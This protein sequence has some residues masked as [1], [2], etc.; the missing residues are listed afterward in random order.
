MDSETINGIEREFRYAIQALALPSDQQIRVLSPGDINTEL[1]EDFK[2][3]YPLFLQTARTPLSQ[4][5]KEILAE[6]AQKL[7]SLPDEVFDDDMLDHQKWEEIRR[8][9]KEALRSLFWSETAP[10]E[11]KEIQPGVW[12]RNS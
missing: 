3:W 8:M 2:H 6:L 9:S 12:S 1:Y 10:P 5:Q 11:F 7:D 4:P